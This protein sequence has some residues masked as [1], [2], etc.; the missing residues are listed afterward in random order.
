M[1]GTHAGHEPRPVP[2]P[3]LQHIE[4]V[5]P[6]TNRGLSGLIKYEIVIGI[7]K[8]HFFDGHAHGT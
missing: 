5:L 6:L 1:H 2:S 7:K 3:I 4:R 8:L